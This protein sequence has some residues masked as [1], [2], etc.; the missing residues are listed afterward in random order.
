MAT[1]SC[2]QNYQI[3]YPIAWN[4]TTDF[5]LKSLMELSCPNKQRYHSD[6]FKKQSETQEILSAIGCVILKFVGTSCGLGLL[7]GVHGHVYLL[8]VSK[9]DDEK[10]CFLKK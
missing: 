4:T 8:Q 5:A 2:S 3:L 6:D 1:N 7:A 9:N 10:Q